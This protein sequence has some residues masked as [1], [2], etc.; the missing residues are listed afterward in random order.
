MI[1]QGDGVPD[2]M[3]LV[4]APVQGD[5]AVTSCMVTSKD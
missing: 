1:A 4:N 2:G 5:A 3:N